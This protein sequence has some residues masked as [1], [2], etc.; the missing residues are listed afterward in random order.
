M[1]IN[2]LHIEEEKTVFL[3][4]PSLCLIAKMSVILSARYNIQTFQL[5]T[6]IEEEGAVPI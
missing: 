3:I 4:I 2:V 6:L 1:K 5:F